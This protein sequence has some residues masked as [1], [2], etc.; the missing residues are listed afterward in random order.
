MADTPL[1]SRNAG[2]EIVAGN[3]LLHRRA[4]L[5]QGMVFAGAVGAWG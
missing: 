1:K 5:G 2:P 3:G 4:L